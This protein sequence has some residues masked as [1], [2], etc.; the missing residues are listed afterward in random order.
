MATDSAGN[1]RNMSMP[2]HNTS[3]AVGVSWHVGT[4][5]WRVEIG[6]GGRPVYL[7]IFESFDEAV[8]A[9][10]VA[11]AKYGFSARHGEPCLT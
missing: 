8:E 10:K 3:G 1:S 4:M 9:R 6:I 5:K 7:G 2:R 11:D